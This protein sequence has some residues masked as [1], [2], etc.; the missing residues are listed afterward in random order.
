MK[1]INKAFVLDLKEIFDFSSK[2][3]LMKNLK[4][5]K[6]KRNFVSNFSLESIQ[7]DEF[8]YILK[9]HNIYHVLLDN[10]LLSFSINKSIYS[11]YFFDYFITEQEIRKE[12]LIEIMK[13]SN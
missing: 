6:C 9:K 7:K 8:Y 11:A 2:T 1:A 12:K 5:F 10:T 4:V 13:V 3:E